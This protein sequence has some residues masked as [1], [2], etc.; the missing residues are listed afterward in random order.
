MVGAHVLFVRVLELDPQ[1]FL[2]LELEYHVMV[3]LEYHISQRKNY[4]P[5]SFVEGTTKLCLQ[6]EISP[7]LVILTE[8]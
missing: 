6:G 4:S 8:A 1:Y 7:F 3:E 2:D 5:F